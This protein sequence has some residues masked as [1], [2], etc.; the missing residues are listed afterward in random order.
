MTVSMTLDTKAII[1]GGMSRQ[2]SLWNVNGECKHKKT[3][4][5][6]DWIS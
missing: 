3:G 5:H 1:S 2:I 4:A 6:N